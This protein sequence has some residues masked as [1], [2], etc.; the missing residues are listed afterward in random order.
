VPG[1]QQR[2]DGEQRQRDRNVSKLAHQLAWRRPR[3]ADA[4]DKVFGISISDCKLLSLKY[5]SL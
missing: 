2:S 1:A 3:T 4:D 5:R